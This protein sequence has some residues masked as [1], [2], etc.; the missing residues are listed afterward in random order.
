MCL[1]VSK[2]L[3]MVDTTKTHNLLRCSGREVSFISPERTRNKKKKKVFIC[4]SITFNS[5]QFKI[6]CV[7]CHD[8]TFRTLQIIHNNFRIFFCHWQYIY[9]FTLICLYLIFTLRHERESVTQVEFSS[10]CLS[11]KGNSTSKKGDIERDRQRQ[12]D[13]ISTANMSRRIRRSSQLFQ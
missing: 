9:L 10:C 8:A 13:S 12:S 2:R 4:I 7:G 11:N 5:D 6:E 3:T 1:W